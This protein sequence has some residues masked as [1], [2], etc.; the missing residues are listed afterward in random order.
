MPGRTVRA[1]EQRGQ[2]LQRIEVE[3]VARGNASFRNGLKP[4]LEF[5]VRRRAQP[6]AFQ[7]KFPQIELDERPGQRTSQKAVSGEVQRSQV[8]QAGQFPRQGAAQ[9]VV[10]KIDTR[11]AASRVRGHAVPRA[12][13]PAAQ[14]VRIVIPVLSVRRAVQRDQRAGFQVGAGGDRLHPDRFQP[15]RV[16]GILLYAKIGAFKQQFFQL[17]TGV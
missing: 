15:G 4:G 2:R 9:I 17:K 1:G 8:R 5:I 12:D 3:I 6:R 11:D 7:P 16:I 10:R 14:P 13:G